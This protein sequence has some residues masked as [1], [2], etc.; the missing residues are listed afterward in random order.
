MLEI[1]RKYVVIS[2][3]FKK[4]ATA[5]SFISQGFLSSHPDRVVRVRIRGEQ[6]FLTVKGR[7]SEDGT[8]RFEWESE[9][10]K[11]EAEALLKLCEPGV[12]EKNRYVIPVGNHTFEVDEFLGENEGLVIAEVELS[13]ANE[14]FEKPSWLGDEVTGDV[15]YYNSELSKKPYKQWN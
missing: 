2:E 4:E 11:N 6:G 14:A 9:I 5:K 13:E 7:S 10:P 3:D 12:V 15:R 1:E 8:T